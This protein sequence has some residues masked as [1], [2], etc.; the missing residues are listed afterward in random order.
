MLFPQL[1]Q[2]ADQQVAPAAALL[3]VE[4]NL[5]GAEA[6]P[7]AEG[8]QERGAVQRLGTAVAHAQDDVIALTDD[9]AY[10]GLD[11]KSVV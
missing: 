6:Y 3:V 4:P 5:R 1:C 7:V 10:A 8:A 9:A 11:R 2:H